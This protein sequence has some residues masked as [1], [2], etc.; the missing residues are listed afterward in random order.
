MILVSEFYLTNHL[1][2]AIIEEIKYKKDF[3]LPINCLEAPIFSD[4]YYF[5]DIKH[6]NGSKKNNIH[7]SGLSEHKNTTKQ[8]GKP[9]KNKSQNLNTDF[10]LLS[11]VIL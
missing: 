1:F 2:Q 6:S 7:N 3:N 11:V 9:Q 8:Y 4:P 5:S 10:R